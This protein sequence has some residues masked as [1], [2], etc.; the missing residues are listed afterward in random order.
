MFGPQQPTEYLSISVIHAMDSVLKG[1]RADWP[2]SND[3]SARFVLGDSP[4]VIHRTLL[5]RVS[6]NVSITR[7]HED[8]ENN[9]AQM[10]DSRHACRTVAWTRT[11]KNPGF[12]KWKTIFIYR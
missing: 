10:P 3:F 4:A 5:I 12:E 2:R 9:G 1:P 11:V 8:R 6:A 7:N